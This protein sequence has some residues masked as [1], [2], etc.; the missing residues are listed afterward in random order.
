MSD[1]RIYRPSKTA[2]QS[3]RGNTRRWALE[4]EPGARRF[5]DPLMGWVG[6]VDTAQQLRLRFAS[7]AEAVAFAKRRGLSYEI[8]PPRE[9]QVRPKNYAE[10]FAFNRVH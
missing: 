2:M 4:F 8:L 6:S 5:N 3:G 7:E 9:R 1:V 10:N